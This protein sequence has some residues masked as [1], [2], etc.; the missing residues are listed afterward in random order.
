MRLCV[1]CG[2]NNSKVE[3]KGIQC[4]DCANTVGLVEFLPPKLPEWAI[5]IKKCIKCGG[6]DFES[7]PL[8]RRKNGV[9]LNLHVGCKPIKNKKF[10]KSERGRGRPKGKGFDVYELPEKKICSECEAEKHIS[11]FYL[12]KSKYPYGKCKSCHAKTRFKEETL[13]EREKRLAYHKEYNKKYK[14]KTKPSDNK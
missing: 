9:I 10:F 2:I 7:N 11:C 1:T 13:A 6:E 8:I 14:N 4:I 12:T 3:F 5:P